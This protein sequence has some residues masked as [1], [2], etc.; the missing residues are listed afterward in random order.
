M[1]NDACL[2]ELKI[3]IVIYNGKEEVLEE[4]NI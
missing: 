2:I 1:S 3:E 4:E